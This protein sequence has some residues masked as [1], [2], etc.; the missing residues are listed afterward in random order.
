VLVTNGRAIGV[1]ARDELT[2]QDFDIRATCILNTAGPAVGPLL[3]RSGIASGQRTGPF[4]RDACLLVDRPAPPRAIAIQGQTRDLD[5]ILGRGRRHLFMVPWNGKTLIGVWHRVFKTPNEDISISRAELEA[6]LQEVNESCPGMNV[7]V[8]DVLAWDYGLV[9]FGEGSDPDSSDLRFGHESVF[10]DHEALDDITHMLSVIGI[11][12]TMGRGDAQRG[13]DWAIRKLGRKAPACSSHSTPIHGGD[14]HDIEALARE[15]TARAERLGIADRAQALLRD[16]GTRYDTVL[17]D[18]AADPSLA[19][20][21]GD[22]PVMAAEVLYAVRH[23]AAQSLADVVLRRTD[24]GAA[25]CPSDASLT[26]CAELVGREHGWS[27]ADM[28]REIL[29]VRSFYP[30]FDS[31]PIVSCDL[32]NHQVSA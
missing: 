29:N 25:G 17:N 30:N 5:A 9:P 7:A 22:S 3:S 8:K 10:L 21:C 14:I 15:I 23:E 26:A 2:G 1:R 20:R 11:R 16:H 13:V 18:I 32:E 28:E 31:P 4:S 6:W 27:G 12:Y 19:R 24:L